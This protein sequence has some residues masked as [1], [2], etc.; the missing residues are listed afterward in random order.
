MGNE[1]NRVIYVFFLLQTMKFKEHYLYI[2]KVKQEMSIVDNAFRDSE[3][4]ILILHFFTNTL[5]ESE[6]YTRRTP[7]PLFFLENQN[8]V[9]DYVGLRKI[10]SI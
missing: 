10:V 4:V 3:H 2:K 6:G 1:I 7:F 5:A 8:V 9:I